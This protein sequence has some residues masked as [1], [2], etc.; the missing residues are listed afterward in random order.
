MSVVGGVHQCRHM[1]GIRGVDAGASQKKLMHVLILTVNGGAN[2]VCVH[3]CEC[4]SEKKGDIA[5]H[6]DARRW[7]NRHSGMDFYQQ[8]PAPVRSP[9]GRS[10]GS[11][12]STE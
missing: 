1:V 5:V 6:S 11:R 8:Q 9:V 3:H 12:R 2:K 4:T 10:V 7:S